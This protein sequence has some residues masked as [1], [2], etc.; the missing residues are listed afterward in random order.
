MNEGML[1]DFT[2]Y[3]LTE[4]GLSPLTVEAY[5]YDI[6]RFLEKNLSPFRQEQIISHL[7]SLKKQGYA[8]ATLA[9]AL[10]SLK[11][12][13][14]FLLRENHA[15]DNP[16][17]GLESPKLWNLIPEVLSSLEVDGLLNA[18]KQTTFIGARDKAILELLYASGLRASEL[19]DLT[20][21]SVDDIAI[22]VCGKGGKERVVPVGS[23]AIAAIDCY[24]SFRDQ[25]D[26]EFLFLSNRGKPLHRVEV[27]KIVKRYAK[28]A[29]IQKSISPHTLRHSFA[30]HL[31]ENGADLRIIQEMLGHV[32]IATTDRYTHVTPSRLK[33]AFFKFHPRN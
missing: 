26:S 15:V 28:E 3:L 20:I 18:P 25:F 7:A 16:T 19:C 4:K 23:K 1:Q 11:V 5:C 21:Y 33:E 30:T 31:L 8:T 32:H 17:I 14:S 29:L 9:R 13:C 27:W 22:K 24:L 6:G 12:F 2:L 10:I